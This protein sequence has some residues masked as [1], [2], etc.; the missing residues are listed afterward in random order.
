MHETNLVDLIAHKSNCSIYWAASC[1]ACVF[2][3]AYVALKIQND[4][5]IEVQ[6]S[7]SVF[8]RFRFT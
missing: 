6:P 7:L 4:G 5:E 8:T 1:H 2:A 3:P